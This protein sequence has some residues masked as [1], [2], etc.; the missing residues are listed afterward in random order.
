MSLFG[1]RKTLKMEHMS[2]EQYYKTMIMIVN[3]DCM[4]CS[5]KVYDRNDSTMIWPVL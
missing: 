2:W 4:L 1:Y 3:Y 5:I